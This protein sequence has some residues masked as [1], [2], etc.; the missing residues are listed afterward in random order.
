MKILSTISSVLN[1]VL[2]EKED[3]TRLKEFERASYHRFIK[4]HKFNEIDRLRN[5]LVY[6]T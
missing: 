1:N 4:F 3:L 6:E 2:S 5:E